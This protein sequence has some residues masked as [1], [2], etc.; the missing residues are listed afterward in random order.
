MPILFLSGYSVDELAERGLQAKAPIAFL[1][2]PFEPEQ[3][4]TTVRG[5]LA[6]ERTRNAG[7]SAIS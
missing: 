1:Q 2:K 5:L 3:L 4:L 6:G 7:S